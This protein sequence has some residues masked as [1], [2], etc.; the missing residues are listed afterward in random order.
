M[1]RAISEARNY[2]L[3]ESTISL[4]IFLKGSL[5]THLETQLVNVSLCEE[6]KY[7]GRFNSL[8]VG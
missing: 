3:G 6:N 7:V 2:L 5:R 4:Q 8:H 1:A